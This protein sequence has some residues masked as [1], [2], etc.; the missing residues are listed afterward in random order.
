MAVVA[1]WPVAEVRRCRSAASRAG[2]DLRWAVGDGGDKK[3][4]G[5]AVTRR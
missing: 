1:V 3:K 2:L 5:S 4:A